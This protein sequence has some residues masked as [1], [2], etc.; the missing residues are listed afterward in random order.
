MA[1]QIAQMIISDVTSITQA[2]Q[3]PSHQNLQSAY[4]ATWYKHS[5]RVNMLDLFTPS[6]P[7]IE[8]QTKPI[9]RLLSFMDILLI[10]L[11]IYTVCVVIYLKKKKITYVQI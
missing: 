10:L 6:H 9:I 2:N 3:N 4:E 8:I 11:I 1:V 7:P 5:I